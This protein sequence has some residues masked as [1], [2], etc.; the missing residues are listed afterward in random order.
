MYDLI[1]LISFIMVSIGV[2]FIFAAIIHKD[3][4]PEKTDYQIALSQV[5]VSEFVHAIKENRRKYRELQRELN[6]V[7]IKHR[8][9]NEI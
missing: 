6:E 9:A 8:Q 4:E 2:V 1:I 3:P 5:N 7:R